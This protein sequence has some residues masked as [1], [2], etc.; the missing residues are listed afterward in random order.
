[1]GEKER[2]EREHVN[3]RKLAQGVKKVGQF[4]NFTFKLITLYNLFKFVLL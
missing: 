1:M 3:F 2:N 4:K